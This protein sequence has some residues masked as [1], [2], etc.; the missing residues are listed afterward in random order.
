MINDLICFSNM[1]VTMTLD[2]NYIFCLLPY[3]LNE[4]LN[5]EYFLKMYDQ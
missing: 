2:N 1:S 3:S 4:V 5:V